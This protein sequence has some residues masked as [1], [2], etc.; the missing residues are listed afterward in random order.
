MQIVKSESRK[1]KSEKRIEKIKKEKEKSE[2]RK[3]NRESKENISGKDRMRMPHSRITSINNG[4]EQP[5]RVEQFG[6]SE[7]LYSV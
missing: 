5:D 2:S 1:A 6:A 3:A 4:S 7:P